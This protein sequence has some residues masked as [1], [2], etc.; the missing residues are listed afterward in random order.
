MGLIRNI[1]ANPIGD[2]RWNVN[3]MIRFTSPGCVY[4]SYFEKRLEEDLGIHPELGL[5]ID[6]DDKF[7]WTSHDLAQS[8]RDKL[9][10]IRTAW[11]QRAPVTLGRS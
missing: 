11:R 7:D 3:I 1:A 2:G 4:F 10:L 9:K 5:T 6:W 8:A